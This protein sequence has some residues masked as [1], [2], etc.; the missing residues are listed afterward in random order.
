MPVKRGET[1]SVYHKI[2][3]MIEF[4]LCIFC[5]AWVFYLGVFQQKSDWLN[6]LI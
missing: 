1:H 2:S 3:A 6:Y 4:I 5:L